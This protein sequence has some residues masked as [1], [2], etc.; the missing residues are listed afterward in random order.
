MTASF[1]QASYSVAEGST[2]EV[3]VTLSADPEREVTVLLSHD[4]QGNTDSDDYSGVPGSVVFQI[5]DTEKSF[6][7][8]AT[9]DDIDDDGESV[10]LGF[11]T[12]PD[13]VTTAGTTATVTITDDDTAGMTVSKT[14]LTIDEGGSGTYTV[15]LDT[16]PT[17]DVT[18]N[19]R[20]P[21]R[22]GH[23]P[24]RRYADQQRAHL[25][26]GELEHGADGDGDRGPG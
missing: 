22:Y 18:D 7:F 9:A 13:D 8:T 5:G 3:T 6:T 21:C 19:H 17:A 10:V 20:G 16:K 26:V 4:P 25:H 23:H 15:V 2:V 24:V 1:G 11:G 12:M 14:A